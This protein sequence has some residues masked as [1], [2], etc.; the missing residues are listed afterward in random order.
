MKKGFTLIELLAVIV[1]LAIISL[2]AVPIIIDIINDARKGAMKSSV[3]NIVAAAKTYYAEQSL[4]ASNNTD[5]LIDSNLLSNIKYDGKKFDDYLYYGYGVYIND[6]GQVGAA[7]ASDGKCYIRDFNNPNVQVIDFSYDACRVMAAG[8]R[9]DGTTEEIIPEG[10]IYR[11]E[12]AKQLA[13]VAE[14]TNS[15]NT[16]EGKKFI[17]VN[18]INMG[19]YFDSNGNLLDDDSHAFT[20]IGDAIGTEF[21]GSFDGQNHKIYNLYVNKT[22]NFAG[23]FG[24]YYGPE[25]KNFTLENSYI[26]TTGLAAGAIGGNRNAGPDTGVAVSNIKSLSNTI[27]AGG[28]VGGVIGQTV[29]YAD[30]ITNCVSSSN[31]T[32]TNTSSYDTG[33]IVGAGYGRTLIG[34]TNYGTVN[35]AANS[36]GGIVGYSK[37]PIIENNTNYGDV[38]SGTNSVGGIAGAIQTNID[39]VT[40][41]TVKNNINYGTIQ[42][43]QKWIGG[44]VGLHNSLT[45]PSIVYIGNINYGDVKTTKGA[46]RVGGIVGNSNPGALFVNNINYGNIDGYGDGTVNSSGAGGIAGTSGSNSYMYNNYNKGNV[47]AKK[48][49]GG[50]SGN[51]YAEQSGWEYD[52]SVPRIVNSLNEGT[53][54]V[55]DGYA[56]GIMGVYGDNNGAA[57][58]LADYIVSA[59]N[60]GTVKGSNAAGLVGKNVG[61][62][63]AISVGTLSGTNNFGVAGTST[64]INVSD[65]YYPNTYTS[66]YG[67]GIALNNITD[68]LLSNTLG[69]GFIVSNGTVKLRKATVTLSGN[70]LTSVTYSNET[71][72]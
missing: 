57:T 23:L 30:S 50:I 31:V 15:G 26:K 70:L 61:I 48:S 67:T 40:D 60:S 17:L 24:I 20:P 38:I 18:D 37:S 49:A 41:F 53:I 54:E 71:L 34:N 29:K 13:W 39:V 28:Y 46:N 47:K 51:L 33:G 72:N 1:I 19:A 36:T 27:I 32:S 5:A 14:Q 59:Y 8:E 55:V 58:G 6:I 25:V 64:G 62:K 7:L 56:G 45:T 69:D 3:S 44:I 63:N 43:E 42:G 16:F 52:L 22:T 21:Y 11:I 9:W 66:S 65:V 12:N 4:D 10:D 35:G 2:I 68:E